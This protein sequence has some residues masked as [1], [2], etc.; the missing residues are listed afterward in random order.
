MWNTN[1]TNLKTICKWNHRYSIYLFKFG[2]SDII[3][4]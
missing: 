4:F 3:G 1:I 2:G